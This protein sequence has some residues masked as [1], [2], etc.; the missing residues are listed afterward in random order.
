[1][2]KQGIYSHKRVMVRWLMLNMGALYAAGLG[3]RQNIQVAKEYFGKGCDFGS[4]EGCD[5]YR[6]MNTRF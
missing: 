1:M 4:Q 3:V 2:Q 5:R 6:K